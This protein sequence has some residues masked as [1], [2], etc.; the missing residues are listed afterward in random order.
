MIEICLEKQHKMVKDNR[1]LFEETEK[2]IKG[3]KI[4]IEIPEKLKRENIRFIRIAKDSK[5]PIDERWSE[6]NSNTQYKYGDKILMEWL[7]NGN[8]YGVICGYEGLIVIDVDKDGKELHDYIEQNFPKTFTVKTWS[9]EE[10]KKHY[11]YWNPNFKFVNLEIIKNDEEI[12]FGEI[13]STNV[14]QNTYPQVVGPG[15]HIFKKDENLEGEYSLERDLNIISIEDKMLEELCSKFATKE[16]LQAEK[17][18]RETI[19]FEDSNIENNLNH[20]R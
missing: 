3:E 18:K 8:N 2:L 15:C 5:K 11:Y 6:I 10:Y 1:N 4:G 14:I 19:K 16:I 20:F 9:K 17:I 7:A 13:R 12:H